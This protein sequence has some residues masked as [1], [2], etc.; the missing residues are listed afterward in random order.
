MEKFDSELIIFD[1]DGTLIDSQR[2]IAVSLNETLEAVS[3]PPLALELVYSYV[4]NGVRP[5]LEKTMAEAGRK[6][7]IGVAVEHFR[8]IYPR[9]LLETT[10]MF[11]EVEE[12]LEH[13]IGNGKKMAIASNKPYGY[14][15][16]IVKGLNMERYFLS[17]KGGD[18][19]KTKK[20]EP[21]MLDT[22][23]SDIGADRNRTVFVGDSAVDIQAGK[24]SSLKTVG[25]TYGFRPRE[26]VIGSNP[27][28][29]AQSPAELRE[30]IR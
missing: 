10:V 5:L 28:A 18:S 4:G 29:V 13:F 8:R 11:D 14:V 20:P 23:I 7:E 12:L 17:V 27:D 3:I 25:V 26:E 30:I 1:L 9:R 2:D 21:E 19:Y 16:D 6:D 24:N 22:I 15:A